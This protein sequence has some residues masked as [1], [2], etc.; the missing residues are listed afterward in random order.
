MSTL[1]ELQDLAK[2]GDLEALY[3]LGLNK[4]REAMRTQESE[5]HLLLSHA[6]DLYGQAAKKDYIKAMWRLADLHT[7]SR[8]M[9]EEANPKVAVDLFEK[10]IGHIEKR[11]EENLM[12]WVQKPHFLR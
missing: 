4:V 9:F 10:I 3:Q 1:E 2:K 5:R 6:A 8:E 12:I 11:I 7:M